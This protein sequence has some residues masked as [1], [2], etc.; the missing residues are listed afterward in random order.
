MT[1]AYASPEQVRGD[2]ITPASDIY[3]LGVVLY[4]LLTGASPYPAATTTSDYEL[5]RAICDTE[6]APPSRTRAAP[7]LPPG[8]RRR[9]HA[10][11]D[12]VVLTA[13]RKD[14]AHRYASAEQLADD[15]FR[16]LEHLPVQARRGAWGYR[17]SRFVLRHRAAVSVAVLANLAVLAGLALAA[18]QTVEANHQRE[19]ARQHLRDVRQ[20]TNVLMF[21]VYESI[22]SLPGATP[23]RE[24]VVRQAR[25]YLRRTAAEP[26]ADPQQRL[27]TA[28]GLRNVGDL[29]GRYGYAN[30]GD[31]PGALETYEAAL[32]LLGGAHPPDDL[33]MRQELVTLY[34]R[35]AVLLSMLGR[36][37]EADTLMRQ[38]LAIAV[39]VRRDAPGDRAAGIEL[40]GL[41]GQH[42][43]ILGHLGQRDASMQEVEASIQIMEP[44]VAAAPDDVPA[45][46]HLSSSY[47]RRG[48]AFL[49]HSASATAAHQAHEQFQRGQEVLQGLLAGRHPPDTTVVR[50]W[51]F[52]EVMLGEAA[53]RLQRPAEAVRHHRQ[54][55][56][57]LT[58]L[59]DIDPQ[60]HQ[61]RADLIR[62][63][64]KLSVALKVQGD[65]AASLAAARAAVAQA[66]HL[67]ASTLSHTMVRATQAQAYFALGRA[68]EHPGAAPPAEACALYRKAL[69]IV[70]DIRRQLPQA[71]LTLDPPTAQA[72]LR[73]CVH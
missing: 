63:H 3:S 17:A 11:L 1:L 12:A 19:L 28:Q 64:S 5:A 4:R 73:L 15:I 46:L 52:N 62:A 29:Q 37:R 10:D 56:H 41:L 7:P 45:R 40:V 8:E 32:Q 33:L 53:L 13:L 24:L 23:A 6:P 42:S 60:D 70:E 26:G 38:A 39:T 20:L 34:R 61:L 48:L 2:A 36:P 30:L 59:S 31:Y 49:Q 22:S 51:A 9:L 54:A 71:S 66:D 68:L 14:P 65:P 58:R 57:E 72:A 18:W 27:E 43:D 50:T 21:D 35:K 67:P 55:V 16:H 25:Q 69:P 47:V 44:L